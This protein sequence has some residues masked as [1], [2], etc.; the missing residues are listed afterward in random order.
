MVQSQSLPDDD[1]PSPF[2]PRPKI[3]VDTNAT[4]LRED[5]PIPK[6]VDFDSVPAVAGIANTQIDIDDRPKPSRECSQCE[7]RFSIEVIE[8]HERICKSQKR[9]PQFNSK[10]HRLADLKEAQKQVNVSA[11]MR[12]E[13]PPIKVKRA[14]W[15][16]KSDQL[17]AAIAL[18]RS[19]DPVQR[20][21]YEA[22]L[23]RVNEA[24]LTRCEFCGRS[25]N[26]EAAQ[27]HIPICKN[28]AMM[29][30]RTVPGKVSVPGTGASVKLPA[31]T[32]SRSEAKP[33][34]LSVAAVSGIP[35]SSLIKSHFR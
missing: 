11:S 7:R 28:K 32:R 6:G 22:E 12:K 31:L 4:P 20:K 1:D 30:P 23:A 18:A 9:R 34:G 33:I 10:Q 24:V 17:R 29:I 8:K 5:E 25:F 16:E 2:L 26:P 13:E 27:R 15:K 35:R 21:I 3:R 19:T 14:G